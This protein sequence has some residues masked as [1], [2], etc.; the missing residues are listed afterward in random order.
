MPAI[1]KGVFLGEMGSR[2]SA[3]PECACAKVDIHHAKNNE[4]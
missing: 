4:S 3:I 1:F 2:D